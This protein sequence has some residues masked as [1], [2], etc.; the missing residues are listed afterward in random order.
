MRLRGIIVVMG[1]VLVA[2]CAETKAPKIDPSGLV[3]LSS[4]RP[5]ELYS[6]PSR[7][8]DDYDDIF[9][10]EV[11]L[12]YAPK[13]KALSDLDSQRLK[14]GVYEIVGR[15]IPAAGQLATAK[16][17]PCTVKLGVQLADLEWPSERRSGATTVIL[18]FTD[19][20]SGDKIVRYTQHRELV[21]QPTAAGEPDLK[22][23]GQTLE[24]VAE[25][26]RLRLRE[27]LPLNRTGARAGQGCK[28]VI[29][30]VRKEFKEGKK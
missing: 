11:G 9:I 24:V 8:I 17:G 6:H 28:G 5:G 27:V 2:G 10:D 16:P 19:S 4:R 26:V 18:E 12:S 3:E 25:D 20:M 22:R 30:E 21:G 15:Q 29:G 23:L 13:Q 14:M 7:S 1:A